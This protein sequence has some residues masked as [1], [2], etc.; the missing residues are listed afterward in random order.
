MIDEF[1]SNESLVL[2]QPLDETSLRLSRSRVQQGR[3]SVGILEFVRA[4]VQQDPRCLDFA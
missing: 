1:I 4:T 3:F 2:Q